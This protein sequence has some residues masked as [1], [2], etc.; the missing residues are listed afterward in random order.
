LCELRS[1]KIIEKGQVPKEDIEKN[2]NIKG[3]P[4]GFLDECDLCLGGDDRIV[5]NLKGI[6]DACYYDKKCKGKEIKSYKN[7]CKLC[8]GGCYI[9]DPGQCCLL[10][11]AKCGE[12]CK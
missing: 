8:Y 2:A 7:M 1:K 10:G 5:T 6:P 12:R 11:K 4:D 9:S 3:V